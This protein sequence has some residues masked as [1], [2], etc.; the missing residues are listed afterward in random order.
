MFDEI[1]DRI[2]KGARH[3][4]PMAAE[5]PENDDPAVGGQPADE[6]VVVVGV[7]VKVDPHS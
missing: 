6:G 5:A 7:A 1:G 4:E 3:L 2:A